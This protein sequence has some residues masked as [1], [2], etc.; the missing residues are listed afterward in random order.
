MIKQIPSPAKWM[1][2][3]QETII[4]KK[5]F[6][7]CEGSEPHIGL[8]RLGSGKGTGNLRLLTLKTCGI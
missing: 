5:F 4:P 2:H 7:C 1:T 6:C 8:P 3:K